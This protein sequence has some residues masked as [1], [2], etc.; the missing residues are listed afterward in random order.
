MKQWRVI[1]PYTGTIEDFDTEAEALAYAEE[2]LNG[3]REEAASNG[4]WPPETDLLGVYKLAH[5]ARVTN[6]GITEMGEWA[7]YGMRP[8]T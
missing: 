5:S 2:V 4:E 8:A 6:T 3:H 7:E 1:D